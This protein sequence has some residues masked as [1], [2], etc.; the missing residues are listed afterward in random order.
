M[1]HVLTA[2]GT[3]YLSASDPY[4][5]AEGWWSWVGPRICGIGVSWCDPYGRK[6]GP[7][8]ESSVSL[9]VAFY[10]EQQWG[11]DFGSGPLLWA[12][13]ADAHSGEQPVSALL[14]ENC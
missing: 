5:V 10:E 1:R 13:R 14:G 7:Y 2:D 8:Q 9:V 11:P 6:A 12:L 3:A 4:N